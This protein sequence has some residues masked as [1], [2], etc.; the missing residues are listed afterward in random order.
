[1]EYFKQNF[2][3]ILDTNFVLVNKHIAAVIVACS[4]CVLGR[5]GRGMYNQLGEVEDEQKSS[6]SKYRV[7]CCFGGKKFLL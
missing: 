4:S 3:V 7:W 1:M 2:V 5:R 6:V